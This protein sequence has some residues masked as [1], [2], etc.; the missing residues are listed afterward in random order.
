MKQGVVTNGAPGAWVPAQGRRG[1]AGSA[2]RSWGGSAAA[3]EG[4][5]K[6]PA[7]QDCPCLGALCRVCWARTCV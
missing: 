1:G 7:E 6:I 2:R 5:E 4:G 3:E